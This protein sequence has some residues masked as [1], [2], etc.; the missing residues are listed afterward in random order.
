MP[1]LFHY[2]QRPQA[3]VRLI[4]FPHAGGGALAYRSWAKTLPHTIDVVAVCLPGRETRIRESL[5]KTVEDAVAEIVAA[6]SYDLPLIFFGHSMGSILAFEVARTL[7]HSGLPTPR[8]LITSGQNAPHLPRLGPRLSHISDIEF[9]PA[10]HQVY[11][12]IPLEIMADDEFAMLIRPILRADLTLLEHY[13]YQPT[14]PFDFPIV[15]CCGEDDI[16]PREQLHEW[17]KHTSAEFNL[18][19]FPGGHFYLEE[20]REV[21]L[22]MLLSHIFRC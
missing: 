19:L 16:Y 13:H 6:L 12:G 14:T 21:L 5:H 11:G 20:Q 7:R 4:C 15:V 3:E 8:L 18:Y 1:I 9:L 17:G 10:V 22:Q 2:H